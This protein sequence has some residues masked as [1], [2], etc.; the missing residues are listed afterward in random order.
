[1]YGP[2][3]GFAA[4]TV[5][6]SGMQA[7]LQPGSKLSHMDAVLEEATPPLPDTQGPPLLD[8]QWPPLWYAQVHARKVI[9]NLLLTKRIAQISVNLN[10]A[11]L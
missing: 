2:T 5:G 9:W 3:E 8:T 10:A 11:L 4:H 6:A 1:M 7:S